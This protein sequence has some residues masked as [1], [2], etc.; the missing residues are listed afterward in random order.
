[1]TS[2]PHTLRARLKHLTEAANLVYF[3][4]EAEIDDFKALEQQ[5]LVQRVNHGGF[6]YRATHDGWVAAGRI[7]PASALERQ[8]PL[9]PENFRGNPPARKKRA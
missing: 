1:M 2:D 5:G 4:W 6:G 3:P 7:P 9:I 8:I